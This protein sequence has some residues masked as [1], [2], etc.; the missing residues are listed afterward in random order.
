MDAEIGRGGGRA[1]LTVVVET[2]VA[3]VM[4]RCVRPLR[5]IA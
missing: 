1:F 2:I 5:L 3:A 4:P